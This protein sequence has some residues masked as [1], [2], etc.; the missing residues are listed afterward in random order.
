MLYPYAKEVLHNN[1]NWPMSRKQLNGYMKFAM[2]K[3]P[4]FSFDVTLMDQFEQPNCWFLEILTNEEL[5]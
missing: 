3:N 1:Y 5:K 2:S 4:G